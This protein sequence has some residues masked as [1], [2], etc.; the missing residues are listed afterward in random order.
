MAV[1]TRQA[2]AQAT[3]GDGPGSQRLSGPGDCVQHA[4]MARRLGEHGD[5]TPVDAG[6]RD[7]PGLRAS[8][9]HPSS[10]QGVVRFPDQTESSDRC[11]RPCA[12]RAI[13]R[14]N[15]GQPQATSADVEPL[16][17]QFKRSVSL[18]GPR[19]ATRGR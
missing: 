18:V 4:G 9:R 15:A 19:L 17:A 14:A 12:K 16:F 1:A 10:V 6:G 2:A 8:G 5:P 13:P 3:M 7:A 11:Q